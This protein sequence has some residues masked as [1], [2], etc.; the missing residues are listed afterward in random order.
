MT[1]I[2][3]WV[4]L[5]ATGS[6]QLRK[7]LFTYWELKA[8]L[9]FKS[10]SWL[11]QLWEHLPHILSPWI[12]Y[13]NTLHSTHARTNIIVSSYLLIIAL[14]DACLAA[15]IR[16]LDNY[17][18]ECSPRHVILEV[19]SSLKLKNLTFLDFWG[20]EMCSNYWA[21]DVSCRRCRC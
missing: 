18:F 1:N 9:E 8:Y 6:F 3:L 4:D 13:L 2:I 15:F 11:Q 14:N 10:K 7:W 16:W 21:V 20:G 5:K 12:V 17:S 19:V